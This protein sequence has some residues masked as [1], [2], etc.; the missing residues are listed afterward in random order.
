[1]VSVPP[2]PATVLVSPKNARLTPPR[3]ARRRPALPRSVDETVFNWV[4]SPRCAP[5]SCWCVPTIRSCQVT[6]GRFVIAPND[7]PRTVGR[8][9]RRFQGRLLRPLVLTTPKTETVRLRSVMTVGAL[10]L[11]VEQ[12]ADRERFGLDHDLRR[13]TALPVPIAVWYVPDGNWCVPATRTTCRVVAARP[14]PSASSRIFRTAPNPR[15]SKG[16]ATSPPPR[17][18]ATGAPPPRVGTTAAEKRRF[19][20]TARLFGAPGERR[21]H[22]SD[23]RA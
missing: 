10:E 16:F 18:T 6:G 9:Q 19:E 21:T 5:G 17:F 22:E 11:L 20:S 4:P 12:E 14:N 23:L 2:S 3:G 1:V 13:E 15:L 8:V 7:H